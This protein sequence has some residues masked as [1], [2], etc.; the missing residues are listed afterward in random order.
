MAD[1][2]EASSSAEQND[3]PPG[4]FLLIRGIVMLL[5]PKHTIVIDLFHR[6]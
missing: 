5:I 6:G 2:I 1:T 4:T 3:L